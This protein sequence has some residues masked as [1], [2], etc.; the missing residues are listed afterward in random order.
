VTGGMP[1]RRGIGF[2]LLAGGLGALPLP[3]AAAARTI[4]A[5]PGNNAIQHAVARAHAGDTVLVHRGTYTGQVKITKPIKLQGSAARGTRPLLD[6]RCRTSYTVEIESPGVVVRH[7]SVVGAAEGF[8]PFPSAVNFKATASGRAQDLVVRNTCRTAQYGINVLNGGQLQIIGNRASGFTDS[9]IY[10][11]TITD[12]HGGPLNVLRNEAFG[13]SRGIIIEFS[14]EVDIR[15]V[16][17]DMHDNRLRGEGESP[18]SGLLIMGSRGILIQGNRSNRNGSYGID[19]KAQS[20][21]N[22]LLGNDLR[23]NPQAVHVDGT[24]GPNCGIG[25]VPNPFDP[26]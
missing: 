26:C 3:G 17:N 8:G 13:N 7:L 19:F 20:R 24:S 22:R 18:P 6:G 2:A 23:S 11:G 5:F 9:G 16:G 15:V 21:N 4:H 14:N 1:I 10:V 12:T 25:N